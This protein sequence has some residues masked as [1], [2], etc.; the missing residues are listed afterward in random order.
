MD[1][2]R[3]PSGVVQNLHLTLASDTVGDMFCCDEVAP[4]VKVEREACSTSGATAHVKCPL[5]YVRCDTHL[6]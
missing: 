3:L 5:K 2:H 6:F 1:R 4:A